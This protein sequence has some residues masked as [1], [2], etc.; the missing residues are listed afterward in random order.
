MPG[1][2]N[3]ACGPDH[4]PFDLGLFVGLR[5]HEAALV[6]VGVQELE[7]LLFERDL[8][9]LQFRSG[10]CAPRTFRCPGSGGGL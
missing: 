2:R 6:A 10:N 3:P 1:S 7:R 4:L 8:F 5:I 9:E